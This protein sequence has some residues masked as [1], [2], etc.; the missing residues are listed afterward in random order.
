MS[1]WIDRASKKAAE[2]HLPRCKVPISPEQPWEG[3]LWVCTSELFLHTGI[4][5]IH[6]ATEVFVTHG[7][8]VAHAE[9]AFIADKHGFVILGWDWSAFDTDAKW[10]GTRDGVVALEAS[11]H[12]HPLLKETVR[13]VLLG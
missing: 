12:V 4:E 6:E 7:L 8:P 10:W 1:K 5:D 11:P 3:P 2:R 9:N 13:M